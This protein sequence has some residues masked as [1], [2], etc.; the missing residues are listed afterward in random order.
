MDVLIASDSANSI[1][2][3]YA[4][5]LHIDFDQQQQA[6]AVLTAAHQVRPFAAVI[7]TDDAST[8]LA[9]ALAQQLGLPYNPPAAVRIARRKD[10]R[11]AGFQQEW[12]AVQPPVFG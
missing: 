7:G 12:V 3:A 8:E 11:Y 2:S 5:G 9:A 6:L 10:A 4:Q 1:I